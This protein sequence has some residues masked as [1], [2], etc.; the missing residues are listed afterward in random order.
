[1]GL[2]CEQPFIVIELEG[3]LELLVSADWDAAQV[4]TNRSGEERPPTS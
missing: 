4:L 3:G 2:R 1:M